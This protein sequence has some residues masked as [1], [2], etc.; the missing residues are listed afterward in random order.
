LFHSQFVFFFQGEAE[1]HG[2]MISYN[3]T[4]VGGHVENDTLQL[5][6]AETKGLEDNTGDLHPLPQ[7]MLTPD[8]IINSA[9][10]SAV[11]LAKRFL[12]LSQNIVSDAMQ[13]DATSPCLK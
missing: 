12:G 9:G 13:E 8:L 1:N 4:I 11:P 7:L 3:T 2:T 5:H 6:I 10:L